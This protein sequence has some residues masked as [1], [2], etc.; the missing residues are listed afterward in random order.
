ML[1]F[2][3]KT[4][5]Y[6]LNASFTGIGDDS[7]KHGFLLT[8]SDGIGIY[9]DVIEVGE[10]NKVAVNNGHILLSPE[11]EICKGQLAASAFYICKVAFIKLLVFECNRSEINHKDKILFLFLTKFNIKNYTFR[12]KECQ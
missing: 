12:E 8:L 10:E 11:A 4:A 3:V 9:G 6:T 7:V 1:G 5:D 2:F